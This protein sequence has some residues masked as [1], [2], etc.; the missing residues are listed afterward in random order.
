MRRFLAVLL[1][2]A[3]LAASVLALLLMRAE[4]PPRRLADHLARRVE[5]S[6]S[7]PAD[8]VRAL[9]RRLDALDRGRAPLPLRPVL[10]IGAPPPSAPASAAAALPDA[11]ALAVGNE[12]GLLQALQ[13][14]QPG[15]TITLLP[16]RY[17]FAG[18]AIEITQPGRADARITL[19]AAQPGTVQL[20]FALLEGFLV[21][22]PHWSF[23]NLTLRG[24]CRRHVDCEHAF[25]VV[26][27]AS[28]FIAR[29]NTIS[30]FNAHFKINGHEGAFPDR[31][32]I[33]GNTLTNSAARDTDTPVTPI[34]LVGASGWTIRT[35]LIADFVKARPHATTYG[36]F[37]KG[38]GR[39]NRFERNVVLCEHGLRGG[40]GS[41][42]G[43]SL[44][45]GGS[46]PSACRDRACITEQEG[47]V[48]E[49]NLVA[50]CSDAGIDVNRAAASVVRHNTLVDTGGISVRH[51]QA[52]AEVEG[53]LVD[54]TLHGHDGAA[55]HAFDNQSTALLRLYLGSHPQRAL[56]A[57]PAALDFGW[58]S[59]VPRRDAAASAPADL[60]GVTRP[61]APAYGAFED[62]RACQR[63][64]P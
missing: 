56:F 49:G 5:D 37:V 3:A 54:G 33:E 62:F 12:A 51:V 23:E 46:Q 29:H 9:A 43:L 22:A 4:V 1:L 10:R 58:R 26:G 30:D 34:D 20:E 36:A 25:H 24:V 35:N 55:L 2:L 57:D 38:A 48:V 16:G 64:R 28:D 61:A 32:L 8:A 27:R 45:G 50:F 42:V 59:G 52:S 11:S 6:N 31:G 53:N 44:G 15:D 47:G 21:S 39:A 41:R 13:A 14:V 17:R 18:R 7:L 60:C 19:R 63:A 40:S